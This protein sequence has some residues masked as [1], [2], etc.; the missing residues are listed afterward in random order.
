MNRQLVQREPR[1]SAMTWGWPF[2]RMFDDFLGRGLLTQDGDQL[3][4]PALDITEDEHA[5]FVTAELPGLK[6][7][8]V[9]IG[10]ENGVLSISGEK[11]QETESKDKNW[12]RMERRFGAFHRAVTL[13]AGVEAD[14][15]EATFE[16]GVLT[17][18]VPK[19]D[20]VKP[21]T[22]KIK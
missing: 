19:A 10:L 11:K 20:A 15:V 5:F 3:I 6:K 9:Q 12:H 18:R 13:P 21:K 14:K 8:E 7:E 17:V 4:A 22:I 1:E 2:G 16:N